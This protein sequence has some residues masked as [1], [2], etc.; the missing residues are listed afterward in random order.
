MA[1]SAGSVIALAAALLLAGCASSAPRA[2]AP[3]PPSPAAQAAQAEARQRLHAAEQ[4]C[5]QL[6]GDPALAPLR[7]RLLPPDPGVPWTRAM[8]VD[9]SYAD[10]RD[11]ALLRIMDDKRAHCRQAMITASPAQAVPLYDYWA[12]QDSALVKLYDR[13]M[14]I[15]SY[16][17]AIADAQA[18]FAIDLNTQRSDTAARANN[19]SADPPAPAAAPRPDA[20]QVSLDSLRALGGR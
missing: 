16:N 15:G 20:P 18:Q 12:R 5:Q 4:L 3:P 17:R 14:P 19:P 11:R 10:A 7:G 6:A 2:A 13:Q 8:M 1:R 9:P